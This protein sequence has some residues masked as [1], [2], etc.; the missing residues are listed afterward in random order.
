LGIVKSPDAI[1]A[2]DNY[3]N[4][5]D[6]A[7]EDAA[8]T[9][10]RKTAGLISDEARPHGERTGRSVYKLGKIAVNLTGLPGGAKQISD[11]FRGLRR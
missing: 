11:F 9:A 10:G 3:V 5:V 6:K 7:F 2:A 4:R 1:E 8:G